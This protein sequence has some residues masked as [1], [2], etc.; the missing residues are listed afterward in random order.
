MQ[1]R[2]MRAVV[3]TRQPA[4][5]LDFCMTWRTFVEIDAHTVDVRRAAQ[6][7]RVSSLTMRCAQAPSNGSAPA[8]GSSIHQLQM[9]PFTMGLKAIKGSRAV[10]VPRVLFKLGDG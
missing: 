4:A 8:A 10:P 2:T 1:N 7:G 6:S 9:V 3:S 5:S